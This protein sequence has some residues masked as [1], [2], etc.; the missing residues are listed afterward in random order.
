[1][2]PVIILK[3]ITSFVL[4]SSSLP[5]IIYFGFV[6]IGEHD[7][8]LGSYQ[9]RTKEHISLLSFPKP[10]CTMTI[11]APSETGHIIQV[12]LKKLDVATSDK[13]D[14]MSTTFTDMWICSNCGAENFEGTA[15]ECCPLCGCYR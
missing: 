1:M 10:C 14:A 11:R 7:M 6:L 13:A 3:F 4:F 8:D 9:K 12:I 15:P 5:S 2:G